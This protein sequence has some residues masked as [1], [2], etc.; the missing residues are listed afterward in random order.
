MSEDTRYGFEAFDCA[1]AL[2]LEAHER[3]AKLQHE[4]LV[5]RLDKI[6]A[7]LERLEK[8][9]WLAVYGVVGAILAQAFQP[10]ITAMP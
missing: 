9:L 10:L 4:A 3:V 7:A 1:P 5:Q 8:R 2:R 6:E